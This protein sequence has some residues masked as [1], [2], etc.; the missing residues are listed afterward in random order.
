MW[1]AWM[2]LVVAKLPLAQL[3]ISLMHTSPLPIQKNA[4][5]KASVFCITT[6]KG[7]SNTGREN[8]YDYKV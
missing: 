2:D 7:V 8:G 5:N 6:F 4:F 3:S 1:L